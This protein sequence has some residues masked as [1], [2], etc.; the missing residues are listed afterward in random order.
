MVNRADAVKAKE[1]LLNSSRPVVILSH[2]NPDGDSVGSTMGLYYLLRD[3]GKQATPVLPAPVPGIYKFLLG[4][5]AV[6]NPPADV[7]GKIAVVLDCSD[8]RRLAESGQHLQGAGCVINIDHHLHN[9]L[10]GDINLVDSSAAAVGQIL[11]DLFYPEP[12]PPPAA[13]ALYTALYSDTGRFSYSNTQAKTLATAAK[14]VE[15]GA[16]PHLVYSHIHGTRSEAYIRFLARMLGDVQLMCNGRVAYLEISRE[17]LAE[18]ALQEWELEELNDYPR[19]LAGVA[20]SVVA[21][22]GQ[23]DSVKVSLRSKGRWNVAQLARDLGG[24]GHQNA[25]GVTLNMPLPQARALLRKRLEEV[26]AL[27]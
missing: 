21:R 10:F 23:G 22:Q 16:D 27:C 9:E 20:V 2:P 17:L 8:V 18:Y 11:F 15:L 19:S 4:D 26:F 24:G 12:I 7:T 6:V 1:V 5:V 25:A 13:L 3:A 14:L